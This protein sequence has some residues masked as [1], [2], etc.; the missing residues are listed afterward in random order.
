MT[1]LGKADFERFGWF[2]PDDSDFDYETNGKFV[3]GCLQRDAIYHFVLGGDDIYNLQNYVVYKSAKL[4]GFEL[5][6]ES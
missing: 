6:E 3:F 2:H 4:G 1:Y 5:H